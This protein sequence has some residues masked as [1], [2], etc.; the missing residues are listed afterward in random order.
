MLFSVVKAHERFYQHEL[1]GVA[2]A[3]M[4]VQPANRGTTLAVVSSLLRIAILDEGDPIVAFFPT[5]HYYS[6]DQPFIASVRSG[7]EAARDRPDTLVLLGAISE[8]PEVEYGW[9]EPSG[10]LER[11]SAQSLFRVN[12]FWEKPSAHVARML[13]ERGCLWN[14]FTMMGRVSAFL[15]LLRATVPDMLEAFEAVRREPGVRLD[16]PGAQD[17]YAVLAP[18]DFSKQVLSANTQNLAVLRLADV[19]WSDLG[20][21]ERVRAA[22]ARSGNRPAWQREAEGLEALAKAAW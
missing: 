21:P 14:T 11:C 3:L 18:G 13:H 10:R 9:I 5:D 20:T 1:G 15:D 19:G 8:Y 6:Q 12:R 17:L 4:V 22:M 2:P 16:T 7:L